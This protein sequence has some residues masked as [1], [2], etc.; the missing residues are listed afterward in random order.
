MEACS[1]CFLPRLIG[2]SRALH[3][4]TTGSTFP[5]DHKLL[6]DLFSEVLPTREA[7]LQR[8]LEIADD[9]SKNTSV[10]SNKLMRDLIYRGTNSAEEPHLLDSRVIHGM[11][12]SEDNLE[13]VHSFFEKRAPRFK[14]SM[15]ADAPKAWPWWS[16]V[17]VGLQSTQPS[18]KAKL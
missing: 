3:L 9:I 12:G 5:A 4:T 1:S 6:S 11:Y 15:K 10:V 7:M 18:E 2:F 14:A 16:Q 17:D 13:G 8:A